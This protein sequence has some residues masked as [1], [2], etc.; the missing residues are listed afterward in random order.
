MRATVA[1]VLSMQTARMMSPLA[2]RTQRRI[3]SSASDSGRMAL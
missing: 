1:I 2:G 3:A